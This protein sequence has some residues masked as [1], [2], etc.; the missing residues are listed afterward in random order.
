MRELPQ[1]PLSEFFDHIDPIYVLGTTYSISPAFFE[2]LVFRKLAKKICG[3]AFS[4]ATGPVS[5]ERS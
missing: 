5:K 3:V 1:R 4:F 2:G